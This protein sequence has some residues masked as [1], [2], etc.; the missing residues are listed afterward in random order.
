MGSC[1]VDSPRSY[2]RMEKQGK[3][4]PDR[5][6]DLYKILLIGDMTVGKTGLLTRFTENPKDVTDHLPTI[7]IDFKVRTVEL[8]GKRIKIQL[9][10]TAGSE[11]FRTLTK[12][13]Y[14]GSHGLIIVY[15]I[16]NKSS[17]EHITS[18]LTIFKENSQSDV[19]VPTMLVGNKMDMEDRRVVNKAR[20]ELLAIKHGLRFMETSARSG[21]NVESAF[22]QV[23]VDIKKLRD[24]NIIK[25]KFRKENMNKIKI[26]PSSA[27]TTKTKTWISKLKC[28]I[29]AAVKIK[30]LK[31]PKCWNNISQEECFHCRGRLWNLKNYGT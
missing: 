21:E 6:D 18:W 26:R 22:L 10:D 12:S 11:R 27:P 28:S 15:D 8:D 30:H 13:F 14:R 3:R 17:F 25:P 20:G 24:E 1:S 2:P 5:I 7:G 19:P 9:W 4:R 29:L 23:A 31:F 16:T